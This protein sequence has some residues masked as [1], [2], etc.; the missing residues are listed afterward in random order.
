MQRLGLAVIPQHGVSMATYIEMARCAERQGYESLWV[1]EA[2]G[3]EAFTFLGAILSHTE[4]IK[5]APGIASIFTRTPALMGMSA[6]ALHAIAP[7]RTLVGL[8]VSTRI[9]VGDW[10]GLAWNHPLERVAEYVQM[11]RQILRGK[12]LSYQGAHYQ[13][14]NFRLGVDAPGDL[15]IYLAAVNPKMLRLAGAVADGVLLTWIPVESMAPVIAEIR[16][17]AIDAGRDPDAMDIALYLRTCVTDDREA[18]IA[19][20]RRDITGYAVADVY[21]RVFRRFGFEAEVNAMQKAWQHGARERAMQQISDPM[22]EALSVIG[23]E[24]QCQA[25]IQRFVASGVDL[26]IVMPFSHDAH[27]ASYLR[28]IT[29]FQAK[30]AP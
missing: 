17:G 30:G 24:A 20:L 22:V 29:A 1:G 16:A 14:K 5:V 12:R 15:P 9:I 13:A 7:S 10:H 18:A 28:T 19:W 21:S 8:G 3:F 11:L 23:T 4:R 6:A 2:N 26:P 27:Q 25:H